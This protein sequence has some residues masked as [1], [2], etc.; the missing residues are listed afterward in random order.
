MSIIPYI[1]N[2]ADD[3][4]KET[5]CT[6][7]VELVKQLKRVEFSIQPLSNSVNGF[8]NYISPNK[9]M[10]VINSNLTEE[11]FNFTLF[12]ELGHY[13]LGH[14]DTLLL[15]SSYTMN[16][17]EEYQADLFATYMYIKY[18]DNYSRDYINYPKRAC[19]LLDKLKNFI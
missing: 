18:I 8:F 14:K 12:H 11:D 2:L 4:I 19:E 7:P 5:D 1:K 9:Q 3:L 10:I 17:K 15:N 16:L 13:F 6:N